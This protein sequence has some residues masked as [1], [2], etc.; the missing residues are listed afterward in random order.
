MAAE[1][2]IEDYTATW[3]HSDSVAREDP[4]CGQPRVR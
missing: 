3:K 2:A 1:P 4:G